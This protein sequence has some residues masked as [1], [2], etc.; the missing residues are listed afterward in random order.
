MKILIDLQAAQTTYRHRGIGRYT[1]ALTHELLKLSKHHHVEIM[2]SGLFPETIDTLR[3]FFSDVVPSSQIIVWQGIHDVAGFHPHTWRRE[4]VERLRESFIAS[5][6]PDVVYIPS[7]FE[8][9]ADDAV[10]SVNAFECQI[11]TAV[12]V[13]D[14][15]PWLYPKPYLEDPMM[16]RWYH[17]QLNQLKRAHLWL[18]ISESSRQDAIQHWG[19]PEE[20]VVN[21]SCARS[22]F[23]QAPILSDEEKQLFCE[24][25]KISRPFILYTAGIDYR[26]NIE[27]LF[28]AYAKLPEELKEQYQL[29]I[30]CD[31]TEEARDRLF[32]RVAWL[33]LNPENVVMT[34]FVPDEDLVVFYHLCTVF[35][36]PSL[37]EGFGLPVLEAMACGAAVIGSNT[38][39][40]P[41]VLGYADALFNPEEAQSIA[42]KLE[43]VLTQPELQTKLKKHAVDQVKKFS[44]K[45]SAEVV[46]RELERLYAECNKIQPAPPF[47]KEGMRFPKSV[48]RLAFISPLPPEKS[49]IANY[50]A[51]L[52]TELTQHYAIDVIVQQPKVTDSWINALCHV[53]TVSWF[54]EHAQ[55]YEGRILYQMGNSVFHEHMFELLA[56][57]PGI[58]VLHDFFM[59]GILSHLEL[60][61]TDP[62]VWSRALYDSHGYHALFERYQENVNLEEVIFKYPVNFKILKHASAIIAHSHFSHQLLKQ[63]YGDNVSQI[64]WKHIPHMRVLPPTVTALMKQKM[65][66]LLGFKTKDF[67]VCSFG[68][69]GKLKLN[70][71]LLNTWLTSPLAQDPRCHLV[72]VGENGEG[73]FGSRLE[74]QIAMSHTAGTIK[75]T[76]FVSQEIYQQYLVAADMAVQ[77]RMKSLGETSGAVLDCMGYGLPMIIN[78]RGTMN[79]I[80]K[81]SVYFLPEKFLDA[82]LQEALVHFKEQSDFRETLSE[83]AREHIKNHHNP[84][85]IA[86]QYRESIELFAQEQFNQPRRQFQLMQSMVQAARRERYQLRKHELMDYAQVIIENEPPLRQ[87][88]ILYDISE[89]VQRDAQ[90]G[91]QRA[92][93]GYMSELIFNPPKGYRIE[94]VYGDDKTGIYYYARS[95]TIN[96]L[97]CPIAHLGDAHLDN[98]IVEVYPG[99]IFLSIDLVTTG[100]NAREKTYRQWK[101]KGVLLYFM[102]YDLLCLLRPEFFQFFPEGG[103]ALFYRWL[104]LVISVSTG[105]ICISKTVAQELNT[106][107]VENTNTSAVKP[108]NQFRK[109]SNICPTQIHWLHLGVDLIQH[110]SSPSLPHDFV[111][112]VNR[113]H[114]HPTIVT[115]GTLETRKGHQQALEAFEILWSRGV[116][117]HWII[118]GKI[119]WKVE[120]LVQMLRRHPEMNQNLFWFEK[121][122]DQMLCYLYENAGG[123][124][125]TSE[126]EGFGLPII[127]AAQYKKPLLV[128]DI[129][130]FR[131]VA[132]EY[133]T[134]FS[135]NTPLDLANVLEQWLYNI[136]Q[137]S[138]ISSDE[139][140]YL[141]WKES[142]EKLIEII[143]KS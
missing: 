7:V 18:S 134:Y 64:L 124:L 32:Q 83:N 68:L 19:L 4:A 76:G 77:L 109:K 44:W 25:H 2:L 39:S 100:M 57:Y 85:K 96:F 143:L 116:K 31:V 14:L 23:F 28:L 5:R 94:P 103:Y 20:W 127:E 61:K 97:N 47:V 87:K 58:V 92:V 81:E 42:D 133:A 132:G 113:I 10:V 135:G 117:V 71:R 8:G 119:G 35:I 91:I 82:E 79:E 102:V 53:Q 80:P 101:N 65:K 1:L 90:S 59:S 125:I 141:T 43:E 78:A 13:Y 126:A 84:R 63:W 54:K 111:S 114:R 67:V 40:I 112:L 129:P 136:N 51:E 128:R 37:Y 48:K 17:R 98:D 75:I 49:G 138:V 73:A 66:K 115:V 55:E 21:A 142:A 131:E 22:S 95:F 11:P 12:T 123:C 88:Q 45:K 50:S 36:F 9:Y 122:T 139:L 69:T 3:A 137:K 6:K 34:G 121:T 46:L 60:R 38:S 16:R 86:D 140:P 110:Y 29:V 41:E 62:G 104:T 26:K 106:W 33:K 15:I 120:S 74:K 30:V 89:L 108:K 24:K 70:D 118:V 107:M 105:L 27:N 130:V 93:R 56:F 99:D 52:L 72:F